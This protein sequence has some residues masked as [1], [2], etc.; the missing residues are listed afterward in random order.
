MQRNIYGVCGTGTNV[1][2]LGTFYG[3]T[4][5]VYQASR[6]VTGEFEVS[7]SGATGSDSAAETLFSFSDSGKQQPE[8]EGEVHWRPSHLKNAHEH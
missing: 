4:S 8:Q 3:E 1:A 2:N 6:V 7:I 5:Q